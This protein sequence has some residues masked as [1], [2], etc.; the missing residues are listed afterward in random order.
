MQSKVFEISSGDGSDFTGACNISY[1]DDFFVVSFE[2]GIIKV[3]AA[4]YSSVRLADGPAYS[5]AFHDGWLYYEE[6]AAVPSGHSDPTT[7]EMIYDHEQYLTRIDPGS[8]KA[9]RVMKLGRNGNIKQAMQ[10]TDK[11]IYYIDP[12]L[13]L[14]YCAFGS[15]PVL[16]D[17]R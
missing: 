4:D 11:G 2:D 6:Q 16:I 3:D 5:V 14:Y 17:K 12:A 13:G 15:D 1:F 10:V 8:G 9:E 7:N